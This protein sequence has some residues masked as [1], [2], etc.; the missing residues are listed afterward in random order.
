SLTGFRYCC[1]T[2]FYRFCCN[3]RAEKLNQSLCRNYKSPEWAHP[4]T[5]SGSLPAD[6]S[7]GADGDANKYDP[8][9][10][11]TNATVY[12][13]CGAIAFVLIA[14]VFAKV[15]YDKARRQPREMNI[16]R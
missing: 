14:G 12:I 15:A 7:N 16:H 13:S 3:K 9:K 2:C 6:G 1:G 5:A 11:S 10:D 8:D 4:T